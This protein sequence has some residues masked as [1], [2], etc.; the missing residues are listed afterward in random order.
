M[1]IH[2]GDYSCMFMA[3]MLIF[4]AVSSSDP[5]RQPRRRCSRDGSIQSP[6]PA[7]RNPLTAA[8][9]PRRYS[10]SSPPLIPPPSL[11]LSSLPP[12][13]N[14]TAG[15]SAVK[16]QT[17]RRETEPCRRQKYGKRTGEKSYREEE[18]E[19]TRA[20]ISLPKEGGNI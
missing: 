18:K 6:D 15:K 9:A 19:E 13:Q 2:Y 7:P 16:S 14:S 4:Q 10:C 12:Q 8:A 17:L 1:I 3:A 5:P 20:D 11:P